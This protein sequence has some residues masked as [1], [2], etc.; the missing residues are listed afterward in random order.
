MNL[1]ILTYFM[2]FIESIGW[3]LLGFVP[4]LGVGNA[5]WS[6]FDKRKENQFHENLVCNLGILSKFLLFTNTSTIAKEFE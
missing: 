2:E 3:I 5:L 4:T 6:R 1:V